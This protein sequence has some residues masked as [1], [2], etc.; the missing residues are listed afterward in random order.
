MAT[1]KSFPYFEINVEDRSIY[2]PVVLNELPLHRPLYIMKTQKGPLNVPVWYPR[3]SDAQR[4]LGRETFNMSNSKY[5]SA[6]SYFLTNTMQHDGAFIVR[7]ADETAKAAVLILE[8]TVIEKDIQQYQRS[9]IEGDNSYVLDEDGNRIPLTGDEATA[10][11]VSIKWGV[12]TEL[13]P[14]DIQNNLPAETATNL[15]PVSNSDGSVTYPIAVFTATSPGAWGNDVGF[16]LSY[17]PKFNDEDLFN[18]TGGLTFMFAPVAKAYGSSIVDPIRDKYNQTVNGVVFKPKAIDS[19]THQKV[20]IDAILEENYS[21]GE[22]L[23]YNVVMYH[24][25]VQAIGELAMGVESGLDDPWKVDI[26][27]ATDMEGYPYFNIEIDDSGTILLPD[28]VTFLGGGEDGDLSDAA[29]EQQI[30]RYLNLTTYPDIVDKA[31]YPITHMFDV[32]YTEDVKNEMLIF[33]DTRDDYKCVLATH[34]NDLGPNSEAQDESLLKYFRH[35]ALL[36][37]ESIVKGTDCCRCTIFCQSGETHDNYDGYLPT[38]LWSA[39]KKAEYQNTQTLGREA[40]GLPF[41]DISIFKKFNWVPASDGSKRRK[42]DHGGNYCQYYDMTSLHFPSVRSVYDY[43]TSV[44]VD[45]EFVDCIVYM[46]HI[47]RRSWAT[48]VGMTEKFVELKQLVETDLS[49]RLNK[50]INGKYETKVTL[51]Q[52]EFERKMGFIHHVAIE[53]TSP[54]TTRVWLV[55]IICKREN[56]EGQ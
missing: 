27:S 48:H 8:A 37:R 22:G 17:N 38:T 41:S 29:I 52:T 11:G 21:E 7:V 39:I 1:I 54:A 15:M 4:V 36:M 32:G 9:P 20:S 40:K 55:D 12:R 26:V 51:Y 31:R 45:D 24:E 25:S 13:R 18:R 5:F 35:Q 14:A 46:K 16:T 34:Q 33:L 53:I 2:E 44:L 28:T 47:V 50:M 3:Y 42:W 19:R 23:P 43:D 10:P 56:F 30:I 6:A 49:D